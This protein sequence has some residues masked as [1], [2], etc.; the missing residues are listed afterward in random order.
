MGRS[1]LPSKTAVHSRGL[2]HGNS[3]ERGPLGIAFPTAPVGW[4]LAWRTGMLAAAIPALA[5]TVREARTGPKPVVAC[6]ATSE[7]TRLLLS[8]C[9]RRIPVRRSLCYRAARCLCYGA[10]R[11]N[12][13]VP[14]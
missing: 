12:T 10:A 4:K 9:Y 2:L 13:G 6:E 1:R 3:L 14:K 11:S 7:L 8:F 5:G